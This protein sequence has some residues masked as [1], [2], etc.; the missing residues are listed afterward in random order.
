MSDQTDDL[1]PFDVDIDEGDLPNGVAG[2]DATD[3]GEPD[4]SRISDGVDELETEPD[5]EAPVV[6]QA[7]RALRSAQA[8]HE[9]AVARLRLAQ[10]RVINANGSVKL[11]AA[12]AVD[13][14]ED[15][16]A[17]PYQVRAANE[18]IERAKRARS[19]LELEQGERAKEVE[20][21]VAA[22]AAAERQVSAALARAADD[23]ADAAAQ[24]A[25]AA[26]EEA[27]AAP[28]LYYAN[29]DE[30]VRDFLRYV[31]RRPID[32]RYVFWS[33]E[34]WRHDEALNRLEAMWRAWE[35]LRLDPATGNSVW[36]RD[37]AD[38]HMRVLLSPAG[39]FRRET[40][41]ATLDGEPLPYTAP[42]P[43]LFRDERATAAEA[44]PPKLPGA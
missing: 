19:R 18:A 10:E 43:G 33:P 44:T 2:D 7:R 31:Y 35:H 30:F 6:V 26:Q 14:E 37:H 42:P 22:V 17:K 27:K 34:W 28:E 13:L 11:A 1:D 29:V 21:A 24:A 40:D 3:D 38:P 32:G 20:A 23:A 16:K 15:E 12:K 9:G 41:V 5:A 8:A 25:A 39:P 36:W 4:E